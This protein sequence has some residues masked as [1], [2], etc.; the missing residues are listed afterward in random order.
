M[1]SRRLH[2]RYR[3]EQLL[4][5]A[6]PRIARAAGVVRRILVPADRQLTPELSLTP[7]DCAPDSFD[8]GSRRLIVA[9]VADA[10]VCRVVV[11]AGIVPGPQPYII[12]VIDCAA[13][14]HEQVIGERW[15]R[16]TGFGLFTR[17]L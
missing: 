15:K 7:R 11:G 2:P 13:F 1:Y 3:I 6:G 10:N 4:P 8:L 9:S 5:P 12:R 16:H 14:L 17:V